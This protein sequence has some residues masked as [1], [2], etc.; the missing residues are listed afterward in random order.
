M[1]I[2]IE[3]ME[4][5]G[6]KGSLGLNI[7]NRSAD[8]TPIIKTTS[9][10]VV[11]IS[12]SEEGIEPTPK[13]HHL[14]NELIVNEHTTKSVNEHK[15]KEEGRKNQPNGSVDQSRRHKSQRSMSSTRAP[16]SDGE[17]ESSS[18][19]GDGSD[20]SITKSDLV[21]ERKTTQTIQTTNERPTADSQPD[22]KQNPIKLLQHG[23][24]AGLSKFEMKIK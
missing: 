7:S 21:D 3:S 5:G 6:K 22:D 10:P 18:S 4:N 16:L 12:S 23:F 8:S 14:V 2:T 15:S 1:Q 9:D 20:L 24:R 17:L 11:V 19:E 13:R